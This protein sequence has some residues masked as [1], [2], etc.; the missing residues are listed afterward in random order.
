MNKNYLVLAQISYDLHDASEQLSEIIKLIQP[1]AEIDENEFKWR[2]A[3][4]YSHLNTA[5]NIHNL[6]NEVLE[7]ADGKQ[8][9]LWKEFPKDLKPL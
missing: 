1:D 4:L 2:M 7:S 6:T 9:D 8:L 3:H 5:W